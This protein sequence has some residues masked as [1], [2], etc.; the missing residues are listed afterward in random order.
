[1]TTADNGF[2]DLGLRPDLLNALMSAGKRVQTLP[3]ECLWLDIGRHEDYAQA[4]EIF[5]AR[6][7]E[8]LP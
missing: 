2:A 7:R 4:I 5:E 8:F 6:K 1:M 3:Q